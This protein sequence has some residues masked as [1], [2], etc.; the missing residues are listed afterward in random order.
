[1]DVTSS[2]GWERSRVASIKWSCRAV[3]RSMV[4]YYLRLCL[5][6]ALSLY[7]HRCS[8]VLQE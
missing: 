7:V 6:T 2:E 1:M 3:P 8:F 4:G 5:C